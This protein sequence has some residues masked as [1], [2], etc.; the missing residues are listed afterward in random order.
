MDIPKYA[1][2]GGLYMPEKDLGKGETQITVISTNEEECK[3]YAATLAT[4]GFSCYIARE[5]PSGSDRPYQKNLFYTYTREDMYIFVTFLAE[6]HT[7]HIIAA[8]PC[9]L[10][11]TEKP[12]TGTCV[13]SV[14]QCKITAGM[15]YA[16]QMADGSFLLL[17]SG[18]PNKEDEERLYA[19]LEKK[20][21]G[22]P[23]VSLWIFTHPDMDHVMM[24]AGFLKD[25]RE[26]VEIDAFAYQFSD[27]NKD[28]LVYDSSEKIQ[29]NADF[30]E[31]S[32]RENYPSSIVYTLRTGQRYLFSGAEVEI[33]WTGYMLYPY[34]ILTA[35]YMSATL[36]VHFDNGKTALF[37]GDAEQ[38]VSKQMACAY[39]DYLKSDILQVAHHGLIG[40][41]VDAYALIDPAICLW[42]TSKE[43]FL[44]KNEK[45]F[46]WCLGE[47]GC[48]FNR[49]IRDD[50]IRKREHYH[51]GETV[52]IPMNS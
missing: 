42:A 14:T 46:K 10:P 50:S 45:R 38:Y 9:P 24:A 20:S 48:D 28:N 18:I 44:G 19:F 49:L 5:I 13:P 6:F 2:S 52:T 32:I 7:V 37:M 36:R 43:R 39:R 31:A 8:P 26:K 15:C 51:L 40:G 33:L 4:E 30:I 21:T 25:Y 22:K 29:G 3:D 23:R 34:P 35:N 16:I 17:D 12:K 11:S 41:D 1:T 47:G 27:L